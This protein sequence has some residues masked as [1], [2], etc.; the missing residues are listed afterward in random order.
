MHEIKN[1]TIVALASLST[2][3]TAQNVV[4]FSSD[5]GFTNEA[6][7][8]QSNWDA[9]FSTG[10]WMVN[11]D[12]GNVSVS[13]DWKR[14]A[15]KQGFSVSGVGKS[16]TFRVNLNFTGTLEAQ[17]NP[18]IKIGFSSSS[19][20]GTSNPPSN[21][22]FLSTLSGND[23]FPDGALLLKNNTNAQNLSPDTYVSLASV[24]GSGGVTDDLALLVTLTLGNDAA[25]STISA[26]LLNLADNTESITG[27]YT[28]IDESVYSA[29]T[30]NIYGYIH[31]QSFS[32]E[33]QLTSINVESVEMYTS[34]DIYPS[35]KR[36]LGT[37]SS[38][39]R[40]KFFNLHSGGGNDI[41]NSFFTNYNANEHGRRFWGPGAYAV[42]Q[43]GQVGSYPTA[44]SGN[45][46][47]REVT[48]YVGT[49][50]PYNM[51]EEGIDTLAL[52][53]WVVEYFKNFADVSSRPE[54]YEPMNEPFVH[55]RDYYSEPDWD[56][57]AEARV[58]LEMAHVFKAIGNRINETP[59]LA[60]MKVIGYA[61]AYPS[62]ERNDFSHWSNNMKM[63]MDEAGIEM[64]GF[65]THLYDGINQV[66]QDTKRSG[67]N[68]EA[69]LDLI[70][71]YSFEKWN[72]V[73]P[74][75]ISEFGGIVGSDYT[76]ETTFDINNAQSIR[77]Q[78]AMLFSLLERQSHTELSIPFTTG[79]S[80]WHITAANNYMPYKAVLFKPV[81]FG[82]PLENVTSWAYTDRIYFYDL[83]KNV[84]GDRILIRSN[85]PDVQTQAFRDGNKLYIAMNNL[86]DFT[87]N[88]NLNFDNVFGS[89]I[90]DVRIK[91]V[92]VNPNET[93]QFSD[94]TY[95]AIPS[96]YQLAPNE[97]IVL[98]YNYDTNFEFNS[99]I[100]SNRYYDDVVVQD[101]IA[102]NPINYNFSSV[103]TST[104][105]YA[106][107]RMS[108][109]R[110]HDKS[111]SPTIV[112]NGSNLNIPTNWK[113]Y[114][115]TNRD[116]F[117]G[118]IEINVP[119]ELVNESNTVSIAFPDSGGH[120]S[121]VVL[122]NET[123][124]TP[125]IEITKT[126]AVL[127][128]DAGNTTIDIG[129][130]ITYDI[131][132]TN[133]GN[134]SLTDVSITDTLTDLDNGPL[135]L[136]NPLVFDSSTDINSSFPATPTLKV[137][138]AVTFK[139]TFTVTQEEIDAGGV[140]NSAS[141]TANDPQNNSISDSTD[142]AVEN[143]IVQSPSISV[144]KTASVGHMQDTEDET[145]TGDTINYTITVSN[146]GNVTLS[147][148]SITDLLTDGNNQTLSLTTPNSFASFVLA[149]GITEIIQASYIIEQSAA[150]SGSVNNTASV[151]ATTP[152]NTTVSD[153]M[154]SPVVTVMVTL[155]NDAFQSSKSNKLILQPNP[156]SGFV[157][158][159]NIEVGEIVNVFDLTGK[160]VFHTSYNGRFIDLANFRKGVYIVSAKKQF[161]KL[162][163][164]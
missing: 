161:A 145:T 35:V 141:V 133:T 66:G 46:D 79:K 41:A 2:I 54:Y 163:L 17:N 160:K 146:T 127:Q 16:I 84:T 85:N 113:G 21:T 47:V 159:I 147:D 162:I 69:V 8:N 149:P 102:N 83:W 40:S 64:D 115:Q 71:S 105:G 13:T 74:H 129:D 25:S 5:E 139:A 91:S 151:N 101:I 1:F 75:I 125:Q 92:I 3:L 138:E 18:L 100:T 49:E 53:N 107:L 58:K 157:Y 73:K 48:R 117:F 131:V 111:K 94:Q 104:A 37:S 70:E 24:Q 90:N 4:S 106:T 164:E 43:E 50:H 95:T 96:Q 9:S 155:S 156:T 98:E 38:L 126:G 143:V 150:D 142:N 68:L 122:I 62:F 114:D 67:S 10:T 136:D 33:T 44:G 32:S 76:D 89:S 97:T 28:G 15:W 148:I 22:V 135:S 81:P 153:A 20:V 109:G 42:Q 118:M 137:G 82:V 19:D 108:I 112:F 119:N 36:F 31:S 134:T 78:N 30:T 158:L 88:I 61:A 56:P 57:I 120:I 39:D 140:S 121:S 14:A 6:L 132:V 65:S 128:N 80:T 123:F 60:N 124:T 7:Y 110:K 130:Q 116:D 29:A 63:F 11:A 72:I 154:S 77:S 52:S 86:D 51:Y 12:S 152:D 55:A 26:T 103:T 144:N 87:Q 45:S 34:V 27:S 93:L 59:E 99:T 23:E